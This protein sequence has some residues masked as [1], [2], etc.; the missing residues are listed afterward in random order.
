MD[1]DSKPQ[2]S[3]G[4]RKSLSEYP[5]KTISCLNLP[6]SQVFSDFNWRDPVITEYG[7]RILDEGIPKEMYKKNYLELKK[8]LRKKLTGY[9]NVFTHNPWGE[10][11]NEEHVQVYRAVKDLQKD[12][13]FDLWFSNYCS[14][15]SFELMLEYMNR[16]DVEY[17]T[18]KT[19]R[20]ISHN[21]KELYTQHGCWTWYNDW[22]WFDDESFIKEKS[23]KE[24]AEK[25]GRAFPL[26]LIKVRLSGESK[27]ISSRFRNCGA[28]LKKKLKALVS[29]V[30]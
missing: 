28:R 15:K 11:G 20:V 2:W 1:C 21:I 17:V 13:G 14:N 8:G 26:N 9:H 6:E 27:T 19:D 23:S 7:L 4:R 3:E 22:E 25:Y 18:L 29:V 5:I 16:L 24:R 10:Y 30:G 12:M